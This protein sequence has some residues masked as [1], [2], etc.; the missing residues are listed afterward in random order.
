VGGWGESSLY[1]SL[2]IPIYSE[3]LRLVGGNHELAVILNQLVFLSS[4]MPWLSVAAVR[5]YTLSNRCHATV[6]QNL[7]RLVELGLVE[8]RHTGQLYNAYL[9]KAKVDIFPAETALAAMV[10]GRDMRVVDTYTEAE[11]LNKLRFYAKEDKKALRLS[12]KEFAALISSDRCPETIRLKLKTL[13]DLKYITPRLVGRVYEYDL[14][15]GLLSPLSPEVLEAQSNSLTELFV[16]HCKV[17]LNHKPLQEDIASWRQTFKMLLEDEYR[18]VKHVIA[19]LPYADPTILA[20]FKNPSVIKRQ[21][22]AIYDEAV[23]RLSNR[24]AKKH[25]SELLRGRK[26]SYETRPKRK[27]VDDIVK[28]ATEAEAAYIEEWL[29]E[30]YKIKTKVG[31]WFEYWADRLQIHTNGFDEDEVKSLAGYFMVEYY[32]KHVKQ[33]KK[34]SLS[35]NSYL[36]YGIRREVYKRFRAQNKYKEALFTNVAPKDQFGNDKS[37]EDFGD[38]VEEF[39]QSYLTESDDENAGLRDAIFSAIRNLSDCERDIITDYHGLDGVKLTQREIA[40]K[41]NLSVSRINKI[42]HKIYGKLKGALID[43]DEIKSR[44]RLNDANAPP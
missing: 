22:K 33:S 12:S 9:Y 34:C 15:K 21:F 26:L 1:D 23:K 29:N 39:V 25:I 5:R 44:L 24:R 32:R 20:A 30:L 27:V 10:E 43:D 41:R 4:S 13:V 19:Y 3:Y 8:R 17:Y 40:E 11:L 18:A 42:I 16:Q 38:E 37:I 2:S 31:T 28:E 6:R 7:N 35:R 14:N 36:I